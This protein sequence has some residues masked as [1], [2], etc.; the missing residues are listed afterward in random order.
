MAGAISST[1]RTDYTTPEFIVTAVRKFFKSLRPNSFVGGIDLDPCSNPNSIIFAGS[2][3]QLEELAPHQRGV[4][5]CKEFATEGEWTQEYT[6]WKGDGLTED[7]RGFRTYVNP[8][9]GK[10]RG[11]PGISDWIRKAYAESR[12]GADVVMCVPD[13]PDTKIWKEVV[14]LEARGRCQLRQRVKFGGMKAGIPKPISLVYFA[15]FENVVGGGDVMNTKALL[16][17]NHFK[18]LGRTED[19]FLTYRDQRDIAI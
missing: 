16:F 7:W 17:R 8:P 19:P 4:L 1:G 10:K 18:W 14:L 5:L 2:N 11:Q 9:F 15:G 3:I 13:A 12:K 6:F